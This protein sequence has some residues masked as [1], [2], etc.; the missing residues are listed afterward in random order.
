MNPS[1]SDIQVFLSCLGVLA[2]LALVLAL[3]LVFLSKK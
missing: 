1:A 2:M 3:A